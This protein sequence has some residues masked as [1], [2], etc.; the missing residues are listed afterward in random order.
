[1]EARAN[2]HASDRELRGI[3]TDELVALIRSDIAELDQLIR[4]HRRPDVEQ[5]PSKRKK[6]AA[7]VEEPEPE[8]VPEALAFHEV[9]CCNHHM[10]DFPA[11]AR[12]RCPFCG[13]WHR[14]GDFPRTG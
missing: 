12:V 9:S 3:S 2:R 7:L 11:M 13:Q 1:M 4:S 8:E 6:G 10:G 5:K 14:A